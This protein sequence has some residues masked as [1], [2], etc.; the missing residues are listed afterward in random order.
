M[1]FFSVLFPHMY[2][3]CKVKCLPDN[4][5][6]LTPSAKPFNCGMTSVAFQECSIITDGP[7]FVYHPPTRQ[8][9]GPLR[10]SGKL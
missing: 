3:P 6:S 2:L 4:D 7:P 10:C 1:S 9:N 8:W 5:N